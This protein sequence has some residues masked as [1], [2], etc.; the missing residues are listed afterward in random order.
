MLGVAPVSGEHVS[1]CEG[2]LSRRI[3]FK[4]MEVG[5]L[6]ELLTEFNNPINYRAYGRTE[7]KTLEDL[8]AIVKNDVARPV[9]TG[10]AMFSIATKALI[11]RAAIGSGYHPDKNV[12]GAYQA[13]PLLDT[14][15]EAG[16]GPAEVQI[17][18]FLISDIA[19]LGGPREDLYKEMLLALINQVSEYIVW[20]SEKQNGQ[21]VTRVTITVINPEK[22]PFEGIAQE[23]LLMRHRVIREVFGEPMGVL[24]PKSVDSRNY[25]EHERFVFGCQREG[26]TELL[27]ANG[28]F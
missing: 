27:E 7:E 2:F 5:F 21:I 19:K 18:D 13:A 17:G 22:S 9:F 20:R 4:R 10:Y 15:D 3:E 28:I 12:E 6:D 1:R 25:S 24:F 26:I 14:S 8:T 23:D 16:K 11:G